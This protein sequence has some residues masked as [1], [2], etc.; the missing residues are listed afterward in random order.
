MAVQNKR[1]STSKSAS[2]GGGGA[3][4]SAS[5]GKA[6][7][8]PTASQQS[9]KNTSG[10]SGKNVKHDENL[11]DLS[12]IYAKKNERL[13]AKRQ[14]G[15]IVLVAF[16]VFLG[17]LTFIEG[18]NAWTQ[19]RSIV[20]GLFGITTFIWPFA[21]IIV[22]INVAFDDYRSS[23][24]RQL[25]RLFIACVLIGSII[26]IFGDKS[27]E[28]FR[29]NLALCFEPENF[30]G[31]GVLGW[32][33]GG[34]LIALFGVIGA[35][36]TIIILTFVFTMIL[37]R[38]SIS[39]MIRS[40]FME[41][42]D[43]DA[44]DIEEK[45]IQRAKSKKPATS[46][47]YYQNKTPRKENLESQRKR[48]PESSINIITDDLGRGGKQK[49]SS[50]YST[51][52]KNSGISGIDIDLG[53]EDSKPEYEDEFFIDVEGI[54]NKSS[55]SKS[56][57]GYD[58]DNN[59]RVTNISDY[60]LEID[61]IVRKAASGSRAAVKRRSSR[62]YS[63][64]DFFEE[65]PE[66]YRIPSAVLLDRPKMTEKENV[67]A[68]LKTNS[69]KLV[70]ALKSF[71]VETKIVD[72]SRGPSVTR[73]EL[74]PSAGV[75]ISRITNLA[76][77]IALN[78]ATSGVRIEAPIPNKAA[79]G[80]EVP[81]KITSVV[82]MREVIESE[83]FKSAK[84]KLTV[85]LGKDIAGNVTISDLSRMPH[86]LIAGSTGSG[87]SVCINSLIVS[88]LYKSKPDEVKFVMIDPKVVELGVYNGIPH[89]LVP[90][91]TDPRKASGALA[92]AVSEMLNR[93]KLFADNNV[94]DLKAYNKLSDKKSEA[95]KLPQIVIIIDELADLMMVAPNEVED[96]ICR[97]A[98]MARAAGMHLVIATQRPSVDVITG[99]IKANIPS[100]IAFSVSSQ[101][102]SRTI[103]DMSGAEKLLGRGDMLFYP[104]GA[105]KPLRV[106]GCY[107]KDSEIEKVIN[108]I[109]HTDA[110]AE[111]EYDQDILKEI[112]KKAAPIK[113]KS[114]SGTEGSEEFSDDM[115]PQ[116]IE[117]VVEAGMASTTHLQRKLRLGYARAARIM[118]ELEEK[119]IV[120]P[121]EGSK[122]RQVLITKQQWLESQALND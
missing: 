64:Q 48:K 32:L 59:E 13:I 19:L 109:K 43:G 15:A 61:D 34:L 16:G 14:V 8:R 120:G 33:F 39:E 85:A 113:K 121:F 40:R 20:F 92:W 51:Q 58:L 101:V 76:D 90:V 84:S 97:L 66:E 88:L 119:G 104:V 36:I 5:K 100:R 87:K 41:R 86:L 2:K 89:L 74:Q 70:S 57:E 25:L 75:K 93:Y 50:T 21:L 55:Q 9:R 81:N 4:T 11:W 112:D 10:S 54:R 103:L 83:P 99:I 28:D 24:S 6:Q 117:C 65:E 118:D 68:E 98:Q 29:V 30:I 52:R 114:G 31:G 1:K 35:G 37:S 53:Y 71:G 44:D 56:I 95:S 106:Q 96:S 38:N 122:P 45:E 3:K 63:E 108:Y 62:D 77:D 47:S 60:D 91:V 116:A 82:S 67:S 94:R 105:A 80:I 26:H 110:A 12:A 72:I 42:T 46:R 78:L 22:A 7:K 79:V 107:V 17:F 73:Y 102:D 111:T 115:L 69:E 49:K 27:N 18:E 23:I